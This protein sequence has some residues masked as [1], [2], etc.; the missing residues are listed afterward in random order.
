MGTATSASASASLLCRGRGP[1]RD[2]SRVQRYRPRSDTGAALDA[3]KFLSRNR[4]EISS[5]LDPRGPSF[6]RTGISLLSSA[7]RAL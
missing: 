6:S 2:S 1:D 7:F 5:R 3:A 4:L